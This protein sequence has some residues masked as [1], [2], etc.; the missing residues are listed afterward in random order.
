MKKLL[1]ITSFLASQLF[2]VQCTEKQDS[3]YFTDT[4]EVRY[5]HSYYQ[6]TDDSHVVIDKKSIIYDKENQKIKCWVIYQDLSSSTLGRVVIQ[7]EYNL[8]NNKVR[9]LSFTDY[10]CSGV[11]IRS[12]ESAGDWYDIIPESGNEFVLNSLIDYLKIK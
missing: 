10:D 9:V 1:L 11:P 12:R 8:K 7:W 3:P 4:N 5:M 6:A 2:A